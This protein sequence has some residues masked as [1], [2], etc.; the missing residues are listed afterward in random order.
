MTVKPVRDLSPRAPGRMGRSSSRPRPSIPTWT[1]PR[2]SG[3]TI[4][5]V[6][7]RS[8]AGVT[9]PSRS[10]SRRA[11]PA[12]RGALA[13]RPNRAES[14]R[15]PAGTPTASAPVVRRIVL[16]AASAALCASGCCYFMEDDACVVTGFPRTYCHPVAREETVC[17]SGVEQA[18]P[19]SRDQRTC[20]GE[21][22]QDR[23]REDLG[24][25]VSCDGGT[26]F[27]RPGDPCSR[28]SPGGSSPRRRLPRA[29]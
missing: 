6:R 10:P 28:A 29:W 24:Y 8:V 22:H 23:D 4:W 3:S 1:A 11:R 19:L 27:V 5:S 9:Q 14:G 18:P 15:G 2:R 21:L 16:A 26:C 20:L 25:A 12:G 17:W 13:R 7:R